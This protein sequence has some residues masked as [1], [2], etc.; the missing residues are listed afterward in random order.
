MFEWCMMMWCRRDA[1]ARR[2]PAG[3]RKNGAAREDIPE[4]AWWRGPGDLL[5][6]L[7]VAKPKE[8]RKAEMVHLGEGLMP[9]PRRTVERIHGGEFVEF[10]DFPV[11]DR[12]AR[13]IDQAEQDLGDRVLVVQAPDRRRTRREVPDASMWG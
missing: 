9:L 2:D 5:S 4:G 10:A 12:G 11:V 3:W 6:C 7:G 1:D 13:A 8:A